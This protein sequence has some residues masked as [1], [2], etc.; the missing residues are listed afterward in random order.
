MINESILIAGTGCRASVA[1]AWAG[2]MADACARFGIASANAVACFLAN[3]GVESR[4]LTVFSENMNYSA[5][6]LAETWPSRFA[7]DPKVHPRVPNQLA[8]SLARKPQAIAN[9]VYA[10][11]LGNGD[12]ESGDGWRCRGQ[13][14]IQLTGRAILARCGAAIG[15]DVL[16]S[17]ELL[18]K[19]QAGALSAAWYFADAG[20]IAAA[21]AGDPARVVKL[22]NGAYPNDANQG[23]LRE[24]RRK[25]AL[26]AI[27]AQK[28]FGT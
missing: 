14:P 6:G 15:L 28:S 23:P 26:N 9:S 5:R 10:N 7:V 11:R 1:K 24:A 21:D 27:S 12:A 19:P 3:V 8:I 18:G 13:G 22:I 16:G 2:P 4:S 20:C 17:P 25:A